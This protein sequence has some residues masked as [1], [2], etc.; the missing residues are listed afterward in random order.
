MRFNQ[1]ELYQYGLDCAGNADKEGILFLREKDR[2]FRR[3]NYVERWFRLKGNI[4]FY[5]KTSDKVSVPYGA[6]VLERCK[7]R[8]DPSSERKHAFLLLFEDC[9]ESAQYSFQCLSDENRDE[10]IT[11]LK[12]SSY[13][14]LRSDM[15][16]LRQKIFQMT[17]KDPL[18]SEYPFCPEVQMEASVLSSVL[19]V[20]DGG[21]EDDNYAATILELSLSCSG[22][23]SPISTPLSTFAEVK[24]LTPPQ[25]DWVLHS[26]T[27]VAER[28][29][30]PYYLTNIVF[31]IGAISMITRLETAVFQLK[32]RE[33][34][35]TLTGRAYF[36]INEIV[37]AKGQSVRRELR[38]D[39]SDAIRGHIT[40]QA[41]KTV[42]PPLPRRFSSPPPE[43]QSAELNVNH[44]VDRA[45]KRSQTDHLPIKPDSPK[46]QKR[47]NAL[48]RGIFNNPITKSYR[49]PTKEGLG[50]L[51][52]WE[53]MGESLFCWTVPKQLIK[54]FIR[55]E[56]ERIND[57]KELVNLNPEW[58]SVRNEVLQEHSNVVTY[59]NDIATDLDQYK[60]SSFKQ[61]KVK[62]SQ[63]LE[64]V[65]TNLHVQRLQV[66][67]DKDSDK[68]SIYD[69][70][71]IGAPAA[72]SLKF[73]QGGLRRILITSRDTN[74]RWSLVTSDSKVREV[75]NLLESISVFKEKIDGSKES[76]I[77][78]ARSCSVSS[79]TNAMRVLR[80]KIDQLK[81]QCENT[82]VTSATEMAA[83]VMRESKTDGEVA[84]SEWVWSGD[85]G[86]VKAQLDCLESSCQRLGQLCMWV[87]SKVN[88]L[89]QEKHEF[90]DSWESHVTPS[91]QKLSTQVEI[92]VQQV[93]TSLQL[94]LL[95]EER[96]WL[97]AGYSCGL[98]G[99]T[100]RRDIIL[101][102]AVAG[103]VTCFIL[104]ARSR[105]LDSHFLR[106]IS[107]LGFLA[108]WESLLST[109][110]DEMGMLEDLSVAV[111]ELNKTLTFTF[112]QSSDSH[113]MPVITGCRSTLQV[114]VPLPPDRFRV[115]PLELQQGRSIRVCVTAFSQG[116][117]ENQTLS[118]AFGDNSF[119]DIV[120]IESFSRLV[121]YYEKYRDLLS[122]RSPRISRE[123]QEI[124]KL[125][126]QLRRN[127]D[128]RKSKN[129]EILALSAEVCRKMNGGR[130]T[131]CKS[132]KDRTSMS[133]TL[134]QAQILLKE[135]N[136]HPSL[137]DQVIDTMRSEGTRILNAEKNVGEKK[138]AFNGLQV[139]ALPK[140]FRPPES[141]YKALQS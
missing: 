11:A 94:Q 113:T 76:L 34:M 27:E 43:T 136:L 51:K 7:V 42:T 77:A 25:N 21:Q 86:F 23:A 127:I 95:Q 44:K 6:F 79:I 13:E 81:T 82:L 131:S 99:P 62:T 53:V 110:G 132:A 130:L 69:I 107:Q 104:H 111:E 85:E 80:D 122:L 72:H 14:G 67:N 123:I 138:Y 8:I 40:V 20:V 63:T 109:Y 33:S 19:D 97:Q 89:S 37:T 90:V 17:G 118:D 119:H 141:T 16:S 121:T 26:R 1:K 55:E 41:W 45:M 105:L 36:N 71:T 84:N 30:D 108:H 78:G 106:Q 9:S 88:A 52:V 73:K 101:S 135:H 120:N 10:W 29:N 3:P 116:V 68:A 12:Q 112:S 61:S 48:F 24:T 133:V 134:T 18:E 2:L 65:A 22:L 64:L 5:L 46:K 59:Y 100:H 124:D 126:Q 92:I 49:F 129:L 75:K 115:L 91:L 83:S 60:I 114:A 54:L 125:L 74:K 103:I 96:T 66:I 31:Y 93:K 102:Q 35:P 117:N 137:F 15:A 38:Q 58:M 28:S 39:D 4:L 98:L 57:I 139:R 70:I 87:E 56:Q 50:A 32:S 47:T 128:S 140:S